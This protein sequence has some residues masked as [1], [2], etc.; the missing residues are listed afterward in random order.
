MKLTDSPVALLGFAAL[1]HSLAVLPRLRRGDSV[2]PTVEVDGIVEVDV[3]APDM[4]AGCPVVF[5]RLIE[6]PT[7]LGVVPGCAITVTKAP[8][9]IC[10]TVTPTAAIRSARTVSRL[11]VTSGT[12]HCT[13]TVL[14]TQVPGFKIGKLESSSREEEVVTTTTEMD[15]FPQLTTETETLTV[16][17]PI[18]TTSDTIEVA[19]GSTTETETHLVKKVHITTTSEA[20]I[21]AEVTPSS[22]TLTITTA[23]KPPPPPSGACFT[24]PEG[25]RAR[26]GGLTVSYYENN[27]EN[28][29]YG[30]DA[31]T[32]GVGPDYY[33]SLTPLAVG[34]SDS[35]SVPQFYGDDGM[36]SEDIDSVDAD[37]YPGLNNTY[38]GIQ[39]NANNFTLVFTGYYRAPATGK[40]RFCAQADNVDNFYLGSTTAFPCDQPYNPATPRNAKPLVR[41]YYGRTK[42]TVCANMKLIRGLYYPLRAVYGNWGTPSSLVFTVRAPDGRERADV[43]D[44]GYP[45]ECEDG[46]GR[47]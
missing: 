10:T 16:E 7:G 4:A 33:L 42:R 25:C 22:T 13:T 35:L 45:S 41:N 24:I 9:S 15:V 12:S 27:M 30:I 19:T 2:C 5:E 26:R 44:F 23:S 18:T 39:Y 40:Y 34:R 3:I 38:E 29:A 21:T 28:Q 1:A 11:A 36:V 20:L 43:N 6:K 17:V 47:R 14:E 8:T 32:G 31:K 46:P 37:Y